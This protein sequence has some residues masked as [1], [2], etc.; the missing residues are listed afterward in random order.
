MTGEWLATLITLVVGAL[1]VL[2]AF[3]TH[4]TWTGDP[5]ETEQP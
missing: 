4:E 2:H 1:A 3:L 5:D